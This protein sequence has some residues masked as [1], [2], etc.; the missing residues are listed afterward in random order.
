MGEGVPDDDE[1]DVAVTDDEP[2]PVKDALAVPV[3]D[4]L[5]VA[6]LLALGVPVAV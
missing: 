1:E 5:L 4:E 6:E 3:W 2:E